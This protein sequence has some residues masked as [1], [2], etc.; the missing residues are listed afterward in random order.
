MLD[1]RLADKS[2]NEVLKE[3]KQISPGTEVV[4]LSGY[5]S[6]SA[7][8]EGLGSGAYDYLLKPVEFDSLYETLRKAGRDTADAAGNPFTG[9]L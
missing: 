9:D 7:G 2:G 3:I 1:M 5:A 6:A 4:I 8:R